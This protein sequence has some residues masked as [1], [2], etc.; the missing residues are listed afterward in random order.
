MTNVSKPAPLLKVTFQLSS[1]ALTFKQSNTK[2]K[3]CFL[4]VACLILSVQSFSNVQTRSKRFS[5]L[6]P[7]LR[8]GTYMLLNKPQAKRIFLGTN[9]CGPGNRGLGLQ[10]NL[11]SL[12]NLDLCCQT[13][14]SC[15]TLNT[16]EIQVPLLSSL[17]PVSCECESSFSGCLAKLAAAGDQ[18]AAWV[19]EFYFDILQIPCYQTKNIKAN[20]I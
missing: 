20:L 1:F 17:D 18:D 5:S 12:R 7:V 8:I 3:L 19:R 15:P 4:L 10:T 13:H 9:W 16:R 2:M 11:G 6:S 14:D